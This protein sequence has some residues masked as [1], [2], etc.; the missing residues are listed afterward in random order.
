MK[1]LKMDILLKRSELCG[2]S[3]LSLGVSV[4]NLKYLYC[5]YFFVPKIHKASMLN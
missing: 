5:G 1:I 3:Y 4:E 2:L